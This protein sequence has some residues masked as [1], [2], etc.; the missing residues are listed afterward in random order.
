MGGELP[1]SCAKAGAFAQKFAVQTSGHSSNRVLKPQK[2]TREQV[3]SMKICRFK[4]FETY[5][6]EDFGAVRNFMFNIMISS[7]FWITFGGTGIL[8]DGCI[9]FSQCDKVKGNRCGLDHP[10]R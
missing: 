3:K 1:S 7:K 10:D 5:S 4:Q 8:E 6:A 9:G 2:A